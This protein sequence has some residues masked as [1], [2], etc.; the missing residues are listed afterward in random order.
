MLHNYQRAVAQNKPPLIADS[1]AKTIFSNAQVLFFLTFKFRFFCLLNN[2]QKKTK[3]LLEVS[4]DVLQ[5]LKLAAPVKTKKV[6]LFNFLL[7]FAKKIKL[8]LKKTIL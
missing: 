1:V 8:F 3:D 4:D 5:E 2:L 7:F 6:L